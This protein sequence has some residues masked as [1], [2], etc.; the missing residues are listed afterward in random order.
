MKVD[1]KDF[2]TVDS[3]GEI[4]DDL[5]ESD[6]ELDVSELS[7]ELLGLKHVKKVETLYCETCENYIS[8][9]FTNEEEIILKHCR[10]KIHLKL[11]KKNSEKNQDLM[12]HEATNLNQSEESLTK[13]EEEPNDSMDYSLDINKNDESIS[14][15]TQA[16]K[17]QVENNDEDD[18]EDDET[19][20]NIDILR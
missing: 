6:N 11:T 13:E 18:D 19:I 12:D 9:D 8:H 10:T 14:E 1:L 17:S 16:E 2:T 5:D 7:D 20:L 4:D 3:I 15:E